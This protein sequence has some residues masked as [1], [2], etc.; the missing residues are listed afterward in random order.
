SCAL[1]TRR[2]SRF[3]LFDRRVQD[4]THK[5]QTPNSGQRRPSRAIIASGPEP[6]TTSTLVLSMIQ[7]WQLP[8]A[9]ASA[10]GRFRAGSGPALSAIAHRFVSRSG[11]SWLYRLISL[12]TA[13]K[14]A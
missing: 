2:V 4:D 8:F 12:Q 3:D 13:S 7:N 14:L 5:T 1:R 6:A 9:T 10:A 11:S